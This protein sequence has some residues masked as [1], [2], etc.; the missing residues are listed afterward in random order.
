MK[1]AVDACCHSFETN[2]GR[3]FDCPCSTLRVGDDEDDFFDDDD[4][5]E[6]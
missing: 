5:E 3:C 4:F 6:E 2:R 1:E